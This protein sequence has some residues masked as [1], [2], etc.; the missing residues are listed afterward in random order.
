MTDSR[1]DTE[2][3]LAGLLGPSSD[4]LTCEQ[5]FELLDIYVEHEVAGDSADRRVPGMREHLQGC[6]ACAEEHESLRD[7][8]RASPFGRQR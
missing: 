1:R 3:L 2:R 5:C 6:P 8:L 4:E 7:L